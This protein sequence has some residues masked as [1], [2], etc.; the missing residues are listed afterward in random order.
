MSKISTTPLMSINRITSF[1]VL[2]EK[3]KSLLSDFY[4]DVNIDQ[5]FLKLL[6]RNCCL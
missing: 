3:D 6:M 1:Q 4:F 5:Q 2:V